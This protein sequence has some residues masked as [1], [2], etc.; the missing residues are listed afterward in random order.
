MAKSQRSARDTLSLCRELTVQYTREVEVLEGEV[1]WLERDLVVARQA[2]SHLESQKQENLQLKE[3][4]D[5][6][7]FDLEEART[8]AGHSRGATSSAAGTMSRNLGAEISRRL[9]EADAVAEEHG[10]DSDASDY[11]ETVVTTQRTKVSLVPWPRLQDQKQRAPRNQPAEASSAPSPVIEPETYV[12]VAVATDPSTTPVAPTFVGSPPAYTAEAEPV[13]AQQ[14]LDKS[15]PH[16]S[17]EGLD[18]NYDGVVLTTGVRCTV[19]ES[20]LK[21]ARSPGEPLS[22]LDTGA[23]THVQPRDH[24]RRRREV[25]TDSSV[26]SCCPP[27]CS[28]DMAR[29]WWPLSPASRIL[30]SHHNRLADPSQLVCS[31]GPAC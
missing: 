17:V 29:I 6:M 27:T 18:D 14:V 5:R 3:T 22:C 24:G 20:E 12:D 7:R 28:R 2:E 26:T 15:H 19:L 30:D 21:N 1:K 13:N 25:R 16:G 23:A 8:T 31:L 11:V 4:I 9:V 10:D